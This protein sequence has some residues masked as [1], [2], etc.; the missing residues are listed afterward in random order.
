MQAAEYILTRNRRLIGIT[1]LVFGLVGTFLAL[2]P[3]EPEYQSSATVIR[4]GENQSAPSRAFSALSQFGF[5]SGGTST[6]LTPASYPEILKS[7]EVR[8][9][10]VRDTFYISKW[11]WIGPVL[12]SYILFSF[13]FCC[14]INRLNHFNFVW[15]SPRFG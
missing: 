1:I 6:G 10:V 5:N 9:A 14:H 12:W 4:E 11:D 8:L 7:R 13:F 3:E 15:F 2:L